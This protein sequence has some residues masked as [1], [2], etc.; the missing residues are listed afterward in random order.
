MP[1]LLLLRRFV[2]LFPTLLPNLPAKSARSGASGP[3]W[4]ALCMSASV[5]AVGR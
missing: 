2:C 1:R 4:D 5:A 3:A